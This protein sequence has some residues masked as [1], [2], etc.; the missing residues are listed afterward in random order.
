MTWDGGLGS[1]RLRLC[2]LAA[3]DRR[4][5]DSDMWLSRLSVAKKQKNIAGYATSDEISA[6]VA[7]A[8]ERGRTITCCG[9]IR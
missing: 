3:L 2:R 1:N 8:F 5:R 6:P 4:T 7:M 9:A